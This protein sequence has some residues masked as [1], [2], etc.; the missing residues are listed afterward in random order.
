MVVLEAGSTYSNVGTITC[1]H[2]STTSNIFATIP[3]GYGQTVVGCWSVP[4][5]NICYFTGIRLSMS[6]TGGGAGSAIVGAQYR[7]LS[8]QAWKTGKI[9]AMSNGEVVDEEF[10]FPFVVEDFT[11]VRIRVLQVS[12][13]NTRVHGGFSAFYGRKSNIRDALLARAY[14]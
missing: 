14:L 1:R 12:A 5:D 8:G 11:D 6:V 10:V 3:A 7:D 4:H 2:S 13:N 9:Y